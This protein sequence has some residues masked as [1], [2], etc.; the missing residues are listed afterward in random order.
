MTSTALALRKERK[1][2]KAEAKTVRCI[3]MLIFSSQK[4]LEL[5]KPAKVVEEVSEVLFHTNHMPILLI[6]GG[7]GR[8]RRGKREE[9]GGRTGN[10]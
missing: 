1:R 2:T 4:A 6:G 7:P 8:E 3:P 10:L 5:F 9:K